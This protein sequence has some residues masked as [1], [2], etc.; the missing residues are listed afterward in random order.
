MLLGPYDALMAKNYVDNFERGGLS[1][2]SI[3]A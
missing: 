2:H 3:E 1:D